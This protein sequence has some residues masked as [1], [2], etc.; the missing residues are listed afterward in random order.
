MSL[1][2]CEECGKDIYD[3][4]S[5]CPQ[6]GALT[7]HEKEDVVVTTIS[8]KKITRLFVGI[9]STCISICIVGSLIWYLVGIS[10]LKSSS[11]SISVLRSPLTD[12]GDSYDIQ[13][14]WDH[15]GIAYEYKS[16]IPKATYEYFSDLTRA[17]CYEQYILNTYDDEWMENLA[18]HFAEQGEEEGWTEYQT[19]C[20]ILSFVQNLPYTSDLVTTGYDNYPRYPVETV[21]DQGGDCE[22]SSILFAS[23]VRELGYSV[24]LILLSEGEHMAAGVCVT[25][26]L[27]DN[28]QQ[29]YSLIYYTTDN[30]II[31][32]YCETTSNCWRF[33]EM[34][35]G[36][37]SIAQIIDVF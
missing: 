5:A 35:D 14:S 26:G 33:G 8:L 7:K 19:I 3:Q 20:F 32:A 6:C 10:V 2:K 34:P 18:N 1:I 13:Y 28:W 37:D 11:N 21:V 31:Y 22:D 16:E 25:Q 23:I 27:I 24:A 15:N 29:P 17:V 36:L 4:A 9:V 12:S 30:G